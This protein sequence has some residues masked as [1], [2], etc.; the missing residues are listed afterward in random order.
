MVTL[1]LITNTIFDSSRLIVRNQSLSSIHLKAHGHE[2]CDVSCYRPFPIYFAI[3]GSY[4]R[5]RDA[6]FV[7]YAFHKV[8]LTWGGPD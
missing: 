2:V 7:S 6:V 5:Y 8:P 3:Y 1:R 4:Y